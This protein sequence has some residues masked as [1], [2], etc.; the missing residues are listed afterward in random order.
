MTDTML[1]AVFKGEG[2]LEL[3]QRPV[4]KI[5]RDDD[6]ILQVGGVG[7]C[8]SDLHILEVPPKHPAKPGVILGHEFAGRVVEVGKGV[9]SLKA[10]DHVAVDPNPGCGKCKMCRNG[11]P[12]CCVP[13]YTPFLTPEALG[14][15]WTLTIGQ[16]WDGGMAEFV[17]VPARYLY[18]IKKH[19][20]MWQVAIFEPIGVVANSMNKANFQ[21]GESAVVLGAGPIGLLAVS[22]LKA[23]GASKIIVSEPTPGR[24]QVALAC[25]ADVVVD[26]AKEDVRERVLAETNG[27]G[28]DVVMEAVGWLFP[29]AIDVVRPFGRVLQL[30]LPVEDVQFSLLKLA[31]TEIQVYGSTLMKYTMD[32][33]TRILEAGLLPLNE[34]ITHRLPLEKVHEGI[35][36]AHRG[37]AAKVILMPTEF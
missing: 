24:R 22:M 12:N 32:T 37:E 23:G 30:G 3:E 19:V 2:R 8:G 21:V 17:R 27:E 29:L 9:D 18:P 26:P 13:L 11:L 34:I 14:P 10:G 33:V 6:V 5:Q 31:L 1:A 20:P 15:Q 7:I 25:G 35:E 28:V 36:L 4:P 16:F